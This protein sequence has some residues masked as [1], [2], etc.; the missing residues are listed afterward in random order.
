[1]LN[2]GRPGADLL[3][4]AVMFILLLEDQLWRQNPRVFKLIMAPET[5]SVMNSF[6]PGRNF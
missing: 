2:F 1:M 4:S 3:D 5:N 6:K